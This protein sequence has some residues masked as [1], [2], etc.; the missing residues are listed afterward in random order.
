ML[1]WTL[2]VFCVLRALHAL[3]KH[4]DTWPIATPPLAALAWLVGAV[5]CIALIV[6]GCLR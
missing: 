1:W 5:V 4:E 2:V 3:D 6:G